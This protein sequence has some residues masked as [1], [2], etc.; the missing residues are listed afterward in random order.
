MV[1]FSL[2]LSLSAS[3]GHL[4]AAVNGGF[5]MPSQDG[6]HPNRLSTDTGNECCF[7]NSSLKLVATEMLVHQ[8][9][10]LSCLIC[11]PPLPCAVGNILSGLGHT[12]SR[13]VCPIG[14][15][16]CSA[17]QLRFP[18]T[19]LAEA[20]LATGSAIPQ[21]HEDNQNSSIRSAIFLNLP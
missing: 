19:S 7:L 18:R 5:Q 4:G 16:E 2:K 13:G 14:T 10:R 3:Q 6:T 15:F 1:V 17:L 21:Y 8:G 11:Q 9:Q 12:V 20:L